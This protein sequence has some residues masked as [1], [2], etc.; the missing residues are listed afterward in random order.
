MCSKVGQVSDNVTQHSQT[1]GVGLLSRKPKIP[2][3][4]NRAIMVNSL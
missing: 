2:T 1:F 4:A 3:M